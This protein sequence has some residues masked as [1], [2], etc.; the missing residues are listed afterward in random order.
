VDAQEIHPTVPPPLERG[1]AS[2]RRDL[3]SLPRRGLLF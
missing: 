2:L 1:S 3:A